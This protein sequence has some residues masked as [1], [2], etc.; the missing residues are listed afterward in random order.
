[1]KKRINVKIYQKLMTALFVLLAVSL[2]PAPLQGQTCS[3][4]GAPVFN[5]LEFSSMDED[6]H[7]H[8]Q[9]TYKYHAIND[10][11]Q[12]STKINDDTDR[13]RTARSVFFETRYAISK[14]LAVMALINFTGHGRE[15]GISGSGGVNTQG[16]GDSMLSLQYTPLRFSD[17]KGLEVS[18]G[19]GV[20]APTGKNTV[21]LTGVAAEDMQP[22]TGSWD[23]MGWVY[24]AKVI[25][26]VKGLEFYA[27]GSYRVNGDNSRDYSFGN[28]L[29]SAFGARFK[30]A[31]PLDYSLYGRYRWTDSDQRFG[32]DVPNTGGNWIY[33]VPGVTFKAFKNGGVKTEFEIPVYRK[34]NGFRQFTSTFLLSLSLFYEL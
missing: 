8:F 4:A 32:G 23:A 31:G 27:S 30:T 1:M 9:L 13:T 21:T 29:I 28:E 17:G 25:D 18:F 5:P 16:L 24:V 19:G 10:L 26:T 11:V 3:C 20:K 12:G 34:L 15:V 14:R 2:A 22:G 6:K 33:I 7:W